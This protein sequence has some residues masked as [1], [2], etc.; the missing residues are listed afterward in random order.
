MLCQV[1]ASPSARTP[2]SRHTRVG[3]RVAVLLQASVV[4]LEAVPTDTD[5][6]PVLRL[7]LAVAVEVILGDTES[8]GVLV[9]EQLRDVLLEREETA[10]PEAEEVPLWDV[11]VVGRLVPVRER[12][13]EEDPVGDGL[14]VSDGASD[15]VWERER[16]GRVQVMLV[17][18]ALMD[19]E[20]VEV[21]DGVPTMKEGMGPVQSGGGNRHVARGPLQLQGGGGGFEPV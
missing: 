19:R 8:V 13:R 7:G 11:V 16:L 15:R 14:W 20:P 1:L 10:V 5:T 6:E 9:P 12:E 2:V 4:V 21:A 17:G 18:V 3:V